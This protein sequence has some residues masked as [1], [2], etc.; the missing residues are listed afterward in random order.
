MIQTYIDAAKRCL[1]DKAVEDDEPF[2]GKALIK[3]EILKIIDSTL[4]SINRR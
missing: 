1:R 2:H 3:P 4:P